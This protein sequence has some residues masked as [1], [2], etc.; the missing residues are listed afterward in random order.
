MKSDSSCVEVSG[1]FNKQNVHLHVLQSVDIEVTCY[2][3]KKGR[4]QT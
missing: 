1:V 2:R 3:N 4:N